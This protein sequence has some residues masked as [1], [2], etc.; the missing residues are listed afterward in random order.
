MPGNSVQDSKHYYFF[1]GTLGV[2]HVL[3]R[4]LGIDEEPEY[5][6]ASIFGHKI[7]MWGPYPALVYAELNP[8]AKVEG[9]AWLGDKKHL[10]RLQRYETENYRSKAVLIQ[11]EG[12]EA[13]VEALTFVWAGYSEDLDDGVFDAS[14]FTPENF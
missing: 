9:K 5:K 1:Y 14:E 3:K 6:S 13:P 2:P 12:E 4:V 11:L 10:N 8:E 7:K